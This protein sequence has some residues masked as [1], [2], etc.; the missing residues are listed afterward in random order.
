M[1]RQ[2]AWCG[3]S[4]DDVPVEPIHGKKVS[5]GICGKC[6]ARL[7]ARSGVPI[8]EFVDSLDEPVLLMDADH[9]IGMANEA[10]LEL[11]GNG[12]DPVL[13]ERTGTVFDCENAHLPGGCGA[14][15]HCSGCVIRHAV[16]HTHLTGEPRLNIPATIR[17][18]EDAG[19]ADVDLV[20]STIRLGGRVLL[21]VE[22]Y[23]P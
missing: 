7:G 16:A 4:L 18:V 21:K 1:Q 20:V 9:T 19:L 17:V 12:G 3:R 11:L 6:H 10:A 13:G 14:T 2:C 8:S 23:G 5:H 22:E 15:I